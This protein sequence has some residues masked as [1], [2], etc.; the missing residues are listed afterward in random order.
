LA[1]ASFSW[2]GLY[3]AE[4]ASA[5]PTDLIASATAGTM[6]FVFM[7]GF[8]GPGL[9]STAISLSGYYEAGFVVLGVMAALGGAALLLPDR[10]FASAPAPPRLC[11]RGAHAMI[12]AG[13]RVVP[14][15]GTVCGRPRPVFGSTG[16]NST[17]DDCTGCG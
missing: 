6:F 1:A 14:A 12:G 15:A 16:R 10:F 9:V 11:R 3:L 4:V 5:A 13:Y 2:N 8:L 17:P 7:G